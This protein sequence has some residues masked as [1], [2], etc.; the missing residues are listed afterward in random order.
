M[1]SLK[2]FFARD[3]SSVAPEKYFGV[4]VPA[5]YE[6]VS[7]AFDN[8]RSTKTA[9]DLAVK[10]LAAMME[11]NFLD[12]PLSVRVRDTCYLKEWVYAKDDS[13]AYPDE[14]VIFHLETRGLHQK[15]EN[16]AYCLPKKIP[17]AVVRLMCYLGLC[18]TI[19]PEKYFV[20]PTKLDPKSTLRMCFKQGSVPSIQDVKAFRG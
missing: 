7:T 1:Q 6:L 10:V 12:S 9:K 4:I 20:C 14:V 18:S 19:T 15:D 17:H 16:F 8:K 11:G 13:G 2:T 3:F 5:V